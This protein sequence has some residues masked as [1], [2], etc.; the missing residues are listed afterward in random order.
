M[1]L[2]H[3]NYEVLNMIGYGLA[4]FNNDFINEFNFSTKIEFYDFCV[5]NKIAT[6][7]GTI[8]NRMDLFDY[9]FPENGRKGWWQKGDAYIHRK[10]LIDNL[11]GNENV[12]GYADIVK[13][14][15]K[16]NFNLQK[17]DSQAKPISKTR[18]KKLRETGLEAELFFINNYGSIE[19]FQDG[20]LE[21]ARL[22]GDGYDF[23]I[24][25]GDN[26]F[27]AEVK[28]V[29]EKK[30]K[31]RLTENEY[32]KALEYKSNYIITLILNLNDIPKILTIEN[33][34]KNLVFEEKIIQSR[35]MK[36]YHLAKAIC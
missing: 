16:E 34:I 6:S 27:L 12:K 21:D 5:N 25:V 20:V 17:I 10:I 33:P 30:G 1:S 22:Y 13:L 23:Q 26:S 14:Y 8:K 35:C 9:F 36:E 32:Q 2:K 19:L 3:K 15:M 4:K 31:F 29:R 11:F 28:G 7:I 24:S 18:F